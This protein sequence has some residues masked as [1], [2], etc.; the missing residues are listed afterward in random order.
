MSRSLK[1]CAQV[2]SGTI[3]AGYFAVAPGLSLEPTVVVIVHNQVFSLTQ[4][5]INIVQNYLCLRAS[6]T[7]DISRNHRR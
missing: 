7:V 1:I 5:N 3:V 6:T 2:E 4:F